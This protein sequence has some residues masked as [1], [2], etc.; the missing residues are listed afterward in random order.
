MER[1]SRLANSSGF[2]LATV[3]SV[4]V[5]I[6]SY[7]FIPL[8]VQQGMEF[9]AHNLSGNA[10]ALYAHIGVAPVALALMPFQ[11]MS[12]LRSRWPA[13]HRWSGRVYVGAILVSGLAG[14][15]LA[16]HT[17]TGAFATVGF[18]TLA[19]VWLGTTGAA[20]Y[21]AVNRQIARH[22]RWMLRSAALTFAAVTLRVY[23]GSSMALGADFAIAYPI[24]SWAC[25]VPNALLVEF[26]LRRAH[27]LKHRTT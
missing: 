6:V 4:L 16:F 27:F 20:F 25:W 10:L 1:I 23:L 7:R 11:F 13:L 18:A 9:V 3:S 22:R 19:V 26:Y 24:I 5:A 2:W 15:Q 8:G 12:V 17:T 21:F 14:L